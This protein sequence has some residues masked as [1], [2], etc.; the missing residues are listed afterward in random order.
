MVGDRMRIG[1][2]DYAVRARIDTHRR[3]FVMTTYRQEWSSFRQQFLC[4]YV[5]LVATAVDFVYTWV[6]VFFRTR[7]G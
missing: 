6:Y 1:Y 5:M 3:D 2:T 7:R 4:G